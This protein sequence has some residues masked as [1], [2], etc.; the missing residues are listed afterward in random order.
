MRKD[1]AARPAGVPVWR[2]VGASAHRLRAACA[3]VA[4]REPAAYGRVGTRY[5]LDDP[6]FGP[7]VAVADL[8]Y[9]AGI[10][11]RDGT[12]RDG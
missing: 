5:S 12:P 3:G 8:R 2:M 9:D 11:L 7:V 4:T 6:L 10:G 1:D